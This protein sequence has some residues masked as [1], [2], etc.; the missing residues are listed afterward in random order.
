MADKSMGD[1]GELVELINLHVG[2][3]EHFG[4]ENPPTSDSATI[5]PLGERSADAIKAGHE[6]VADIDK[7]IARLHRVREQLVGELRTDE[8]IRMAGDGEAAACGVCGHSRTEH[9]TRAPSRPE[10]YSC[11]LCGCRQ[12]LAAREDS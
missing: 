6:A 3:W 12:Y 2:A 4:Y 5:P 1:L 7:L 8:D 9:L 11:A 10:P